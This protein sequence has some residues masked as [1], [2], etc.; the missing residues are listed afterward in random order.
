VAAED[1]AAFE[2]QEEMLSDRL[3]AF[4]TL[5]VEAFRDAKSSCTRMRR[6]DRERLADEL[7]Q[8]LGCSMEAVAFWHGA[9]LAPRPGRAI[10]GDSRN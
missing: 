2:R 7:A 6:L 9:S 5:P 4:E 10:V 8:P 1:Q 3:G